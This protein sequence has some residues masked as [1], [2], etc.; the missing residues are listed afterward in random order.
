[1]KLASFTLLA[2]LILVKYASPEEFDYYEEEEDMEELLCSSNEECLEKSPNKPICR[3]NHC[4]PECTPLAPCPIGQ[5][6]F[7]GT[8]N[9][10]SN[11]NDQPTIINKVIQVNPV[12][13]PIVKKIPAEKDTSQGSKHRAD[14]NF[15]EETTTVALVNYPDYYSEYFEEEELK[16]FLCSSNKECLEMSPNKPICRQNNCQPECTPL[17][18]CPI[19]QSCFDGRCNIESNVKEQPTITNKVIQVN[20]VHRSIYQKIFAEKDTPRGSK[21]RAERNFK[22]ET[23]TEAGDYY[24]TDDPNYDDFYDEGTAYYNDEETSE[25][26]DGT[27]SYNFYHFSITDNLIISDQNCG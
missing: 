9:I 24:H 2:V 12:H 15:K 6:C 22:E 7:D 14:R 11:V 21:H 17:A 3:Q 10:E 23:T 27:N 25:G 26:S 5:S 20:P 4:Q 16:E 1:M 18:P 19:G 13:R 8:C